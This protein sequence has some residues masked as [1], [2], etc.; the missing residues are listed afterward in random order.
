[1]GF[2]TGVMSAGSLKNFPHLVEGMVEQASP[3]GGWL[4]GRGLNGMVE[5]GDG[6]IRLGRKRVQWK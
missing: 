4:A 1:M 3:S 6:Q 5:W 2:H